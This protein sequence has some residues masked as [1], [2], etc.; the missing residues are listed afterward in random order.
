MILERIFFEVHPLLKTQFGFQSRDDFHQSYAKDNAPLFAA[1]AQNRS[2]VQSFQ[3]AIKDVVH[4]RRAVR[5]QEIH[6]YL[7]ELF[8]EG[9]IDQLVCFNWDDFIERSYQHLY[10]IPVSPDPVIGPKDPA[11]PGARFWKPHGCVSRPTDDWVLPDQ[12]VS[13]PSAFR[14]TIRRQR[15]APLVILCLGFRGH[16]TFRRQHIKRLIGGVPS[17]DIRP[18]LIPPK[19]ALAE[20]SIGTTAAYAL[21]RILGKPQKPVPPP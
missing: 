20:F 7:A 15:S 16:Q 9:I 10:G 5:P 11:A 13:I 2:C 14:E 12:G 6:E 4:N 18:R 17:Y 21:G 3:D 8:H 1:L 19:P